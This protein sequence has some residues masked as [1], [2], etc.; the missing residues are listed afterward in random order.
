MSF[1]E[2]EGIHA[3]KCLESDKGNIGYKS[4]SD[5]EIVHAVMIQTVGNEHQ[6]DETQKKNTSEVL[7]TLRH[8]LS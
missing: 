3:I 1:Q 7:N 4:M 2:C 8:L 5:T 6:N